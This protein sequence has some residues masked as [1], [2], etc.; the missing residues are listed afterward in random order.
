MGLT[1]TDKN[2][3]KKFVVMGCYG[4]GVSRTI[5]ALAEKFGDDV[6]VAFPPEVAPFKVHIIP[7]N[8]KDEAILAAAEKIHAELEDI[9]L[10]DDREDMSPGEKFADCDLW[11]APIKIVIGKTL[12]EKGKI[13][14]IDRIKKIKKEVEPEKSIEEIKK[15]IS[16]T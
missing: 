8:M 4:I 16:E 11:G 3:E 1:Y 12:K 15:M 9:S 14:V 10:L 2:K 7:I 6:G 5:A 13:E